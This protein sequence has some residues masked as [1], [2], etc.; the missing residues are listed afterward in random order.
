V[1]DIEDEFEEEDED[2]WKRRESEGGFVISREDVAHFMIGEAKKATHL[3]Q[4]HCRSGTAS[5]VT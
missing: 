3:N 4:I 2:D 1:K 5:N